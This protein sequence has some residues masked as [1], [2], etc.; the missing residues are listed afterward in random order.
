MKKKKK[1]WDLKKKF[2]IWIVPID[3]EVEHNE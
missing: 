3:D 1:K 2:K